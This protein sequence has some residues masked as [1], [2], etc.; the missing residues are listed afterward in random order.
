MAAN[1]VKLRNKYANNQQLSSMNFELRG[2]NAHKR[3]EVGISCNVAARPSS[4]TL[5]LLVMK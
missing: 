1:V 4:T 2:Y 3:L 5:F